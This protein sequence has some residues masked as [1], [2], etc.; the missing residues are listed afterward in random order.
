VAD[1]LT[2]LDGS[3]L[4]LE[5]LDEGALMSL[6][7]VMVFDP[8]AGGVA[9]TVEAVREHLAARL[10]ELPRYTQRLSSVRT[11]RLV[12]P[13][14]VPDER[15]DIRHH[16][17][18]DKLPTPGEDGQLSDWTAEFFSRPLDRKRPLWE[19]VLLE[20]LQSGR[21]ALGW[22]THH[23]L[24][25]GVVAVELM[26]L[27]LGPEPTARTGPAPPRSASRGPSSRSHLPK[28][29]AQAVDATLRAGSAAVHVAAHPR[30]ALD[31]SR[32]VAELIARDELRGAPHTSLNVPIGQTRRYA[33]VRAPLE[34]LKAI[35]HHLGGSI[36]D[37]V[38]AAATGGLRELLLSRGE[39]LPPRGLRALVPVTRRAASDRLRLGNMLSFWFVDLPVGD[40]LGQARLRNI[41]A[42]TR[43]RK[44]SGAARA[45]SAMIEVAA[46]AP[47]VIAHAALA[48]TVFST[49]RF[50]VAVT[51]VPGS[52][53]PLYAF[54]A[55]VR[56]IRPVLPLLA[57]HTVGIAAHSYNGQVTFGIAADATSTPDIDVLARG[58]AE[59]LAN[60]YAVVSDAT[61]RGHEP[62]TERDGA[63]DRRRQ[64]GHAP[65]VSGRMGSRTK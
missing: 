22:K 16:V 7:G 37:V 61:N 4:R 1:R 15:F 9:P 50:N 3:F 51:N 52:P 12:W 2:A 47:P 58:I 27:L 62:L 63:T 29:A 43:R 54:G 64:S 26:G 65:T 44:S 21:W 41:A 39:D 25:D 38:L 49:R 46:L 45:M 10:G 13:R 30:E 24:V 28:A 17:G 35:G 60:L 33:V 42:A 18:R 20:G 23:C 55:P 8:P 31:R 36:T 19:M 34:E 11:G 6:G 56:E 14:W 57:D 53:V 48:Q 32:R 40:P 59:D 5:E